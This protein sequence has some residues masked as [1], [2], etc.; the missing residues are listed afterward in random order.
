MAVIVCEK[1]CA[2]ADVLGRGETGLP[3]FFRVFGK[4]R[5]GSRVFWGKPKKKN[6]QRGAQL[7][8]KF[9]NPRTLEKTF[10][11]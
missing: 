4:K 7:R 1:V 6:C 9:T 8:K 5:A 2:G 11:L 10:K 3:Y